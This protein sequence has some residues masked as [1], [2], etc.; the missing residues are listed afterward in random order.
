[1]WKYS[2][3]FELPCCPATLLNPL[4]SSNSCFC[5][6]LEIFYADGHI[7]GEQSSFTAP[8]LIH[9][10]LPLPLASGFSEA[11]THSSEQSRRG[12]AACSRPSPRREVISS[13]VLKYDVSSR[14]FIRSKYTGF[15]EFLSRIGKF[16]HIV[17]AEIIVWFFFFSLGTWW[18][19]VIEFPC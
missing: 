16:R 18:V 7:T 9:T 12:Q 8:F 11:L 4:I 17:P 1:M 15:R 2:C 13:F 19:T 6:F 5:R 10:P 3:F 14:V